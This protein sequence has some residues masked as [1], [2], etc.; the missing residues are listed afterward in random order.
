MELMT[1]IRQYQAG[2][3][4]QLRKLAAQN[5]L[6]LQ[7]AEN[8]VDRQTA[9]VS[10]YFQHII[11]IQQKHT[12]CVLVA[13]KDKTLIGF[14]CLMGPIPPSS[15]DSPTEPYAFM[16]DLFV[17]RAC[18]HQGVGNLLI[19]KAE[20]QARSM[21]ITKIALRVAADNEAARKIY[22]ANRYV[23][24]FIVMSKHLSE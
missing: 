9:A 6:S 17:T 5:Y 8:R 19:M 23:E 16:S 20:D 4:S 3:E 21:G 7:P 11:A 10:A 14:V 12:G 13:E 15:G 2:D 18:R 22:T 24:N 1:T